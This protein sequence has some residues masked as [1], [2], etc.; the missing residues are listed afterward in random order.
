MRLPL[1]S[2]ILAGLLIATASAQEDLGRIVARLDDDDA[3]VRETAQAD[4]EAW[5]DGEGDGAAEALR[6]HIEGSSLEVRAR[7]ETELQFLAQE[8]AALPVLAVYDRVERDVLGAPPK[9]LGRAC[10]A[11]LAEDWSHVVLILGCESS[12]K[13]PHLEKAVRLARWA[14]DKGMRRPAV[15]LV[16]KAAGWSGSFFRGQRGGSRVAIPDLEEVVA[17]VLSMELRDAA[18]DQ[19]DKGTS[20]AVLLA[21]WKKIAALQSRRWGEEA[22]TIVEGYESLLAEDKGWKDLPDEQVASLAVPAQVDYWMHA[23]RDIVGEPDDTRG[24]CDLIQV[25]WEHGTKPT[26]AA[27]QLAALEWA[28]LPRVIQHL[29]DSRPTRATGFWKF[30]AAYLITC[31]DCCTQVFDAITV[32]LVAESLASAWDS[33]EG[34]EVIASRL[35]AHDRAGL[36]SS[37]A[38]SATARCRFGARRWATRVGASIRGVRRPWPRSLRIASRPAIEVPSASAMRPRSR[39]VR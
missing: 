4:L 20:R 6:A 13:I 21:E 33:D 5:C 7:L 29:D 1:I 25:F 3:S 17:S 27:E 32:T 30:T 14:Y 22:R 15:A 36:S 2:T 39:S 23:L 10:E 12:H 16:A 37:C 38:A 34:L 26:N 19:A 24:K 18:I 11:A 9:D 8:K 35:L 28:A 31:G